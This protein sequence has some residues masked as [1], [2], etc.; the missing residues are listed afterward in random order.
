[1][2]TFFVLMSMLVS[3][4][5]FAEKNDLASSDW[6]I[7]KV[8][9]K[10]LSS[11]PSKQHYLDSCFSYLQRDTVREKEIFEYA[12]SDA[13]MTKKQ[14]GKESVWHYKISGNK[15]IVNLG[16]GKVY[17]LDFELKSDSLMLELDKNRFMQSEYAPKNKE[18]QSLVKSLSLQY[19]FNRKQ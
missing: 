16:D 10:V 7:C 18:V 5:A 11:D 19:Y 6:E 1:M 4:S 8:S 2:R 9:C 12:F 15:L 17:I 13:E 3:L 14:N